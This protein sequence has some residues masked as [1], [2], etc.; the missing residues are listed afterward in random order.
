MVNALDSARGNVAAA[1][2][3]VTNGAV[4]T[5]ANDVLLDDVE[6]GPQIVSSIGDALGCQKPC[7]VDCLGEIAVL[8][9]EA[10][11]MRGLG[12]NLFSSLS[13]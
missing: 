1:A 3:I 4:Q 11:Y 6:L 13:S 7:W 12:N 2:L 9:V 10:Q 8:I 5:A